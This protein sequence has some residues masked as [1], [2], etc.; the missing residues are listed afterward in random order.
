MEALHCNFTRLFNFFFNFFAHDPRINLIRCAASNR[1]PLRSILQSLRQSPSALPTARQVLVVAVEGRVG[2][3]L[4][5]RAASATTATC[6][7]CSSWTTR[8]KVAACLTGSCRSGTSSS[9][10][11]STWTTSEEEGWPLLMLRFLWRLRP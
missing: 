8:T 1:T 6:A 4:P 2:R 3:L 7:P 10:L 11:K 5:E 9:A